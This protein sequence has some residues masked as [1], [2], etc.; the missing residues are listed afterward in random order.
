MTHPLRSR[1]SIPTA[2]FL[3]ALTLFL[4]AA[5][6]AES[7]PEDI[8]A[9]YYNPLGG[10]FYHLDPECAGVNP[11]YLPLTRLPP[12]ASDPDAYRY[13]RPCPNCVPQPSADAPPAPT[14][15][16]P[17]S[18][19]LSS[20]R[21]LEPADGDLTRDQAVDIAKREIADML[22]RS[23][24]EVAS[25]D[26]KA[27]LVL[28]PIR[29]AETRV[30]IV[31]FFP[32]QSSAVVYA[33]TLQSPTGKVLNRSANFFWGF[34]AIWSEWGWEAYDFWSPED[35]ALYHTLYQQNPTRWMPEAGAFPRDEA[36]QI[37][38]DAV[39]QAYGISDEALAAYRPDISY[40]PGWY[41]H[42]ANNAWLI[43]LRP[44]IKEESLYQ[45]VVSA[46]DGTVF[47]CQR[48]DDR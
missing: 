36:L 47:S 20:E 2:I 45:I 31:S 19:A 4:F 5:L 26:H 34:A 29:G 21:M 42:E 6:P 46:T 24:A 14:A 44:A 3:T 39:R 10:I 41:V 18:E 38:A 48:N 33:V 16:V 12:K 35:K 7:S 9:Y 1:R 23:Q 17:R 25:L 8:S 13:L 37:A 27:Y 15:V 11:K 22:V 30:W 32:E 28:L 40:V 43:M